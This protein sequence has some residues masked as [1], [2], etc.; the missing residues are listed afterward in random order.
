MKKCF[1]CH[2]KILIGQKAAYLETF[3]EDVPPKK[4]E[5]VFM[6]FDCYVRWLD[7]C[8]VKKI[9]NSASGVLN[10]FSKVLGE[11]QANPELLKIDI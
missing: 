2:Q 7:E 6:H 1:K 4:I 5:K 3:I 8:M 10:E 11:I 9:K